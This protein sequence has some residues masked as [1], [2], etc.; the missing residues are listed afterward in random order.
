MTES[1]TKATPLRFTVFSPRWPG[2]AYHLSIPYAG[3]TVIEANAYDALLAERDRLRAALEKV[4]ELGHD[5]MCA[6]HEAWISR[7]SP[8]LCDCHIAIAA[9][10]LKEGE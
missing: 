5:K 9:T 2:D 8:V 1:S 10:A 6:F 7:Q 4:R 3:G